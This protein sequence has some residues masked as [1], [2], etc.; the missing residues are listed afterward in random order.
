MGRQGGDV[1]SGGEGKDIIKAGHGRDAITGG[2]GGDTLF[3]GFGHNIFTGEKDGES[4]TLSFKSDQH[5]WNWLYGKSGNNADGSK[6]DVIHSLDAIYK[7]RIEGVETSQLSFETVNNFAGATGNYSGVGIYADRFLEA[8]YTD[9]DL[10]ASQLKS[11]TAG[12]DV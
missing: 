8:I 5:L 9:G 2:D 10:S 1:L 3:G 4:D 6:L 11:M 12:V 7:I